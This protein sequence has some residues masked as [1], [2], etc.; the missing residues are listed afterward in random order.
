M[1][2]SHLWQLAET[3]ALFGW[4]VVG[5]SMSLTLEGPKLMV[6]VETPLEKLDETISRSARNGWLKV[7]GV[8]TGLED[9]MH[10][11]SWEGLKRWVADHWSI[12]VDAAVRRLGGGG[13]SG[14][15]W[16]L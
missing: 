2:T 10:V 7:L 3:H 13:G 16:R 8:E 14:A 12:V 11:K 4:S 1:G 6:D 5:L 9:L 15:S